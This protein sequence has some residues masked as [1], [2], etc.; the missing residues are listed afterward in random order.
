MKIV[1]LGS[2]GML[3]SAFL[4]LLTPLPHCEIFSF[5]RDE[6]DI[7]DEDALRSA[8]SAVSPNVVINCAGFT[9][10]DACATHIEEALFVNAIAVNYLAELSNAL[11]FSLVHFSTDYVFGG[12][13]SSGYS[14]NTVPHPINIYGTSKLIGEQNI[15]E[16]SSKYFIIRTSWLFGLGGRNFVSTMLELAKTKSVIN[17]VSDQVGKPTFVDDLVNG[18]LSEILDCE[19]ASFKVPSGIYH[20]T[21]PTILS[22]FDFAKL[23][24]STADVDISLTPVSSRDFKRP[25]NRPA[26]SILLNTKLPNLDLPPIYDALKRYLSQI[27]S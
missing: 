25:A 18:F 2:G 26:S 21:N 14:E 12:L 20:I 5:S 9:D 17:V 11:D 24:F 23:I 3:G 8:F 15:V 10:V 13:N 16:T 19:N 27:S 7:T 22:W 4:R 1:I 6:L